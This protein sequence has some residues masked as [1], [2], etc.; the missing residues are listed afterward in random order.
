MESVDHLTHADLVCEGVGGMRESG[1]LP[2]GEGA[3]SGVGG[4]QVVQ[5]EPQ[6]VAA[7]GGFHAMPRAPPALGPRQ[8]GQVRLH[9]VQ[10]LAGDDLRRSAHVLHV[11]QILG[12][13]HLQQH[14]GSFATKTD[15]HSPTTLAVLLQ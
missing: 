9:A 3:F 1:Y 15:R 11:L 10:H 12:H 5:L 6:Q 8:A 7:P 14:A 2:G 13:A 4:V